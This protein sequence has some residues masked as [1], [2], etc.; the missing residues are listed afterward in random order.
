MKPKTKEK[1]NTS[2]CMKELSPGYEIVL[3]I[4]FFVLFSTS[5]IEKLK[6]MF[7][8]YSISPE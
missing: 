1:E 6:W 3:L 8:K 2:K 5:K 4:F 7:Y